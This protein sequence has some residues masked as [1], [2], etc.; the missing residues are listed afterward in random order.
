MSADSVG[1]GDGKTVAA[2][3]VTVPVA[4]LSWFVTSLRDET[5]GSGDV[6][7]A[8]EAVEAGAPETACFGAAA[9]GG[10]VL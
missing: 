2:T 10:A 7:V 8:G 4:S 1:D 5:V 6:G 9:T 3:S